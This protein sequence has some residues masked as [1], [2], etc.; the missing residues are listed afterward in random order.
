METNWAVATAKWKKFLGWYDE[1]D[2]T[3]D[4]MTLY[5]VAVQRD[6]KRLNPEDVGV[7]KDGDGNITVERGNIKRR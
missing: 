3:D 5:R 1:L 2:T 4:E 7:I 6:K